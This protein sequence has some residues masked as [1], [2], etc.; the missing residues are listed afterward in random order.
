[1]LLSFYP[2]NRAAF[3]SCFLLQE[4]ISAL[5]LKKSVLL[6]YQTVRFLFFEFYA[7]HVRN[8]VCVAPS[9]L[10]TE[11][12]ISHISVKNSSHLMLYIFL[13]L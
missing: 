10:Y 11:R 8:G 2:P 1:M 3:P 7:N 9:S 13:T 6:R 5:L 12:P 4:E